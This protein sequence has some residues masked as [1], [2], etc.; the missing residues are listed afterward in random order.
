MNNYKNQTL[1]LIAW[2]LL[3]FL[4]LRKTLDHNNIHLR[5][6]RSFKV[7]SKSTL[8]RPCTSLDDAH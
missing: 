6:D 2:L 7:S 1:L 4:G 5:T 3:A 8:T